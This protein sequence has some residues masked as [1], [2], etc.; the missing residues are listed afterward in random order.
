MKRPGAAAAVEEGREKGALDRATI[1]KTALRLLDEVGIDG[2]STRRLAAELGIKSASLYWHFKDKNELLNEMS[3]AMFNE[4]LQK[5]NVSDPD[6][7]W[8]EWLAE[9]AR[10]IR[11]TALSRRDGAQVMAR[12]RPKGPN[13]KISFEDNVK[14]VMRSG[15][16]DMEARLTMQTLRRYAI[17]AALQEQSNKGLSASIGIVGTGDEG[18]EFGL[19]IFIDGLKARLADQVKV[20]K[21]I[22]RARSQ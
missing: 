8:A 11:R 22:K 5:P 18:F 17:G 19:Q 10:A 16:A 13:A 20:A 3:G 9:G 12:P 14:T 1:V 2:L 6:F 7:D 21:T 4:C 15:L